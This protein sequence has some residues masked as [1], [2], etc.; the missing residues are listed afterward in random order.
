[1]HAI[2]CDGHG[3][4]L[5]GLGPLLGDYGSA[6]HIGAMAVQAAARANWHPRHKTS[7]AGIVYSSLG[8]NNAR[9]MG[10]SLI[11]TLDTNQ[12]RAIVAHLAHLVDDQARAGDRVARKII[13]DAA[14]ALAQTVYDAYDC[15]GMIDQDYCLVGTGSVIEKSDL[16]VEF[17]NLAVGAD[18]KVESIGMG[19]GLDVSP[20]PASCPAARSSYVVDPG[21]AEAKNSIRT[22]GA[23]PVARA[24][25]NKGRGVRVRSAIL[26]GLGNVFGQLRRH[27]GRHDGRKV[28]R[29]VRSPGRCHRRFS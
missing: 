10:Q 26:C 2:T 14:S 3:I 11:G 18:A 5:D 4:L 24:E 16:E 21:V 15:L 23:R 29:K 20:P 8:I 6:Y 19:Q 17:E 27:R 13:E 12:D 25:G 7:L 22:S 9:S 28:K 1:M